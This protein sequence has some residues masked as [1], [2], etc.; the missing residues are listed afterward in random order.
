MR[1]PAALALALA[2]C[3]LPDGDYFGRIPDDLDARHFRWCN[4]GEPD[5]LD[6]ARASSTVSAPL[7]SALYAGLTTYGPDGNPV[8][9]LATRWDVDA[10]LRTFTFHLRDDARWTDG[11]AVTA[12]DVA[13]AAI[14]VTHPLTGSPNADSLDPIR[15][16]KGYL[17]GTALVLVRDAGP[18]RAGEVVEV[19]GGAGSGSGARADVATRTST[20]A[21]ALRDLGAAEPAA[22]AR[23]PPGT[24]VTLVMR[25][26]GRATLPSP[27]GTAWA[28]VYWARDREGVFGWVPA[29]ELDGHPGGDALLD[30]RGAGAGAP[31]ATVR[32][33]ARDVEHS[34][35]VLGVRVPDA[36]TIVFECADPTP[37]FLS[38]TAGRAL[39]TAPIEAVSR[40]PLSW[41]DPAHV[42]TSGP[43]HL[44]AW[45]P[46]DRVELVRSPTYWDP[47][48]VKL[49]RLTAFSIDDQAAATN[50]Y[51]AGRC[52]AVATNNIPSTYLPAL[53]GE[54]RGGRAYKDYRVDPYLTVYFLW[55][56]TE[57]L[58]NR[59][60]RRALALAVDRAQ[61]PRFTHGGELP[62]SQLTPG[63]PIAGLSDADLAACGV[64]RDA[65]GF[66]LVMEAGALCY[67]PPPGLDHDPEAARR[68]LAL[69]RRHGPPWTEPLQ[70]R[71]NAGSE[72]HKQIAE[73]LQAAWARLGVRVEL[74]AQE[75]NSLLADT[76]DGR[77]EIARLGSAGSVADTESEFLPLFRCGTKDNRGRYCSAEFERLMAEAR[78]LHDRKARNA[79]LA[80]AEAVVLADAP[81]IPIYVYTQ[82]HLIKPYVRDYAINIVDQP[83]LW[84][85]WL[86]PA[87]RPAR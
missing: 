6:P 62:T 12:Y 8:A 24:A 21:L 17:T 37:F 26:G 80:R 72:A 70:Y 39:R 16:A 67:V 51:F 2:A 22:Y 10:E 46:R 7:I 87:W 74:A 48:E 20:R 31:R 28:D 57:K 14:R 42:V 69:A 66:A 34:P 61:V 13:Y 68:E 9:S 15:H 3:G 40:R 47:D 1:R 54:L 45:R 85:V 11:R 29:A 84:R 30:V 55:L 81:I 60:L 5:Y 33:R 4:Q 83:S 77:F 43:L 52:D 41:T 44:A 23:V 59:H 50:Y 73:Y 71:Y 32:V 75:W 49:D 36:R 86:D 58:A 76:H 25:T 63:T 79:V 18:Y 35:D 78:T 27:G 82:K 53:N 19:V 38:T 56:N 64:A 65:P